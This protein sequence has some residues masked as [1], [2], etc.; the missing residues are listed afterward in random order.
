MFPIP[1]S[2]LLQLDKYHW[3]LE[4]CRDSNSQLSNAISDEI[5][6]KEPQDQHHGHQ[7]RGDWG[8]ASPAVQKSV[9][10]VPP[11]NDDISVSFFLTHQKILHFLP[12][13][14]QCDQNLRRNEILGV[15]GFG[16]L[17]I[18]PP[19]NKTLWWCPWSASTYSQGSCEWFKHDLQVLTSMGKI[20]TDIA[21]ES[22]LQILAVRDLAVYPSNQ[23]TRLVG[24]LWT[25][26]HILLGPRCYFTSDLPLVELS[27]C[28][29]GGQGKGEA[30]VIAHQPISQG[31]KPRTTKSVDREQSPES[32]APQSDVIFN[33]ICAVFC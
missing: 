28:S 7:K 9:G 6:S 32:L 5:L 13:S 27:P 24:R 26:H 21:V 18:R 33:V 22:W 15:G 25:K 17:W 30:A 2:P 1:Q 12:F 3:N 29:K 10:D 11:K 19:Q 14:K 16:C 8:N 20:R 31:I 4:Q 23:V